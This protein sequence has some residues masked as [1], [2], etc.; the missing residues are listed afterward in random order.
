M[1]NAENVQRTRRSEKIRKKEFKWAG[2]V[3]DLLYCTKVSS[4][5]SGNVPSNNQR[6]IKLLRY[7]VIVWLKTTNRAKIPIV[8][9]DR[10]F[11]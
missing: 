10:I 9:D 11:E 2:R 4:S 1:R 5:D 6:V 8:F 3:I 7:F